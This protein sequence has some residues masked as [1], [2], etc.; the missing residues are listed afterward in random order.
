MRDIKDK[1]FGLRF[2]G[3]KIGWQAVIVLSETRSVV[4]GDFDFDD[5]L[6]KII[7][8]AVLKLDAIMGFEH[9]LNDVRPH[10]G[11]AQVE[12]TQS[13]GVISR[14]LDLRTPGNLD[15]GFRIFMFDWS[16]QC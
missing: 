6:A 9:V 16:E 14:A 3:F 5:A 15:R 8:P 10:G 4:E 11:C 13:Q 2:F 12:D 7:H 1:A